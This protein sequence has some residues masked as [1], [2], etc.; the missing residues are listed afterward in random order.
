MKR[1]RNFTEL[2]AGVRFF[3]T[4]HLNFEDAAHRSAIFIKI[5]GCSARERDFERKA[6]GILR[7]LRTGAQLLQNFQDASG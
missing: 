1:R 6:E 2:R 4:K 5:S 3:M 7:M